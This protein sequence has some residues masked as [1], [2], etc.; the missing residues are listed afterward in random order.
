MLPHLY[1]FRIVLSWACHSQFHSHHS[2]YPLCSCRWIFYSPHWLS[3]HLIASF[4][5]ADTHPYFSSKML[6]N[7]FFS[8]SKQWTKEC[9]SQETQVIVPA[10]SL[11]LQHL[12]SQILC[13]WNAILQFS[14][15]F[16]GS[17]SCCNAHKLFP[18][19]E[20]QELHPTPLQLPW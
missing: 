9:I 17:E 13:A 6:Q 18:Q 15:T 12:F 4:L 5:T 1:P 14:T 2:V 11:T 10:L 19:Q 7:I 8:F 3:F 20:K 16:S